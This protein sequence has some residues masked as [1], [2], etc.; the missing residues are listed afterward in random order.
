MVS[1]ISFLKFTP[2]AP[3]LQ[4]ILQIPPPLQKK[5]IFLEATRKVCPKSFGVVCFQDPESREN[6]ATLYRGSLQKVV[7]EG[8]P[9][10]NVQQKSGFGSIVQ[11]WQFFVTFLGWLSDPFKWLLVT[12]NQVWKGHFESPGLYMFLPLYTGKLWPSNHPYNHPSIVHFCADGLGIIPKNPDPSRKIGG[13]RVP[14]PSEK[15]R[16]WGFQSLP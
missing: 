6:A 3:C 7:E 13:L 10:E 8:N 9:R 16:I 14:I 4:S 15:S 2:A 5:H 1:R 12:S 11:S